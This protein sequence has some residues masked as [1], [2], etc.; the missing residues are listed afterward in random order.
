MR[1]ILASGSRVRREIF[2]MIGWKYEIITSN[3]EEHS[4]SKDPKQ[5]VMDLAK[6]KANSVKNQ[7]TGE[8]LI[9]AADSIIYMDGKKFEKPKSKYEA[10]E[11]IKKMSGKSTFALTGVTIIDLYKNEEISFVDETEVHF[12]EVSETDIT[13]YV[14]NQEYILERAGYSL[15]GKAS[16]FVDKLVGDYYNVLGMPVGMLYSKLNELGYSMRDFEMR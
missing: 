13:W 6:H 2:D 11:N 15:K 9:I 7:I 8:A 4:N 5:Y 14:E 16:L 1:L 10:F 12:K 3:E